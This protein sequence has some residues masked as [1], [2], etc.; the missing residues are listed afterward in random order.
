M[1]REAARALGKWIEEARRR[2]QERRREVS[3]L[4]QEIRDYVRR[5]AARAMKEELERCRQK[6]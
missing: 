2:E 3:R 1:T 5:E 4:S 6:R